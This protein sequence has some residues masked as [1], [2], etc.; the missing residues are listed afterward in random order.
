MVEERCGF[1]TLGY[2]NA[3]SGPGSPE[4]V[5]IDPRPRRE[6]VTT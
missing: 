3:S 5:R 6:G 2:D 1:E 4:G